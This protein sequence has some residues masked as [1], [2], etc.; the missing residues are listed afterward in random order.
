MRLMQLIASAKTEIDRAI[1]CLFSKGLRHKVR[2]KIEPAS[3]IA[4]FMWV[5]S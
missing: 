4:L 1:L 5:S 2:H 3:Q